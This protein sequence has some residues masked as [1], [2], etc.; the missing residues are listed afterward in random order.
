M[1]E[2]EEL[3][4]ITPK[5]IFW[6]ALNKVGLVNDIDNAEDLEVVVVVDVFN[7]TNSQ[8]YYQNEVKYESKN[9][10]RQWWL[11]CW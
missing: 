6:L 1:D 11:L 4:Q 3:Y 10:S 7:P 2:Q 9:S 5:G 8:F